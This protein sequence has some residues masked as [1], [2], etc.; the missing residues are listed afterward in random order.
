MSEAIETDEIELPEGWQVAEL[1]E[2]TINPKD[3]IVDGPFGSNL[4]ASEY[5]K[6]GVPIVRLQ[7]I[8]RNYFLDKN[9][10]CVTPEKAEQL[11]RH[12]FKPSDI[13]V[14]KLGAPLGVACIAP[15]SIGEGIIVADLVRVRLPEDLVDTKYIT[16]LINSPAVIQRFK[17]NTKGTTRPR[18]NLTFMR[19]LPLPIAPYKQQKRIV[20]KIE[21][22]FSHIDAGIEALKKAKQ[23]LKQYRQSVLKAAVTGELTKEW[24]EANSRNHADDWL[25]HIAGLRVRLI[26]DGVIAKPKKTAVVDENDLPYE[27]P[28]SWKWTRLDDFVLT[29]VDCPHSTPKYKEQGKKCVRTADFLPGRL[30]MDSVR[31]VTP[32]AF[33]ERNKRLIPQSDDILYSREGGILGIAC[34]I[35]EDEEV[36]LGQRMMIFRTESKL[37]SIYLMHN[38]N[39]PLIVHRV[40][41]LTGGSASPHLNVGEIRN[42]LLPIPSKQECGVLL[43]VLDEKL[44]SIERLEHEIDLQLLKAEKYKQS[45]LASAFS[46]CL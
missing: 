20:A 38:L 43:S 29:S 14:T 16:Y 21:E 27:I 37:A 31:C 40:K 30:V 4:K 19:N 5:T 23:L 25:E 11:S 3:D 7:N 8:K 45:A 28:E 12:S 39:S 1:R 24:R 33:D 32:E 18:V 2:L 13:L 41:S 22:L 36:C 44:S 26:A 35:P 34:M 46:G 15:H 17:E 9:I 6:T 42:F 10:K